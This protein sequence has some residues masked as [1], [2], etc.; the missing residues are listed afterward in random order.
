[1]NILFIT[2]HLPYPPLAGAR[3]RN[4]HLLKR[5]GMEH[6]IWLV[7]LSNDEDVDLCHISALL[8]FCREVRVFFEPDKGALD[9]PVEGLWYL[10]AGMPPDL[11]FFRSAAMSAYIR[12]LTK[13]VNFDVVEIVF[14]YMARFIEDLPEELHS[15]TVL[16]FIDV[17][18]SKYAR[19]SRVEERFAR[20]MREQLD[21]RM[22]RFWEPR[23]AERF[24]C[25]AM[26]SGTELALMYSMNPRLRMDVVPNGVDTKLNQPLGAKNGNSNLV[27]VGNMDYAANVDAMQYFMGDI[28]PLIRK[29]VPDVEMWIVGVNPRATIKAM[30]G[31]G[32]HVTGRVDDVRPYYQQSCVCVIPLRAGAGTRL[33]ILESMALGRV[34]VSTSI[35]YEGIE[36]NDGE[37]LL[38]ADTADDFA[39]KTI[40]LIKNE[41][42]RNKLA[43]NARQL[44]EVK[45]DW[46][47]VAE[48]LVSIYKGLNDE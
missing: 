33:K 34:V 44:V 9:R 17:L 22:M 20:R 11:R 36:A 1:M 12:Q 42:Q 2:H 4:F 18:F 43:I 41:D 15:K 13:E 25:C 45:Y 32:I 8:K 39:Q 24:G 27:F 29:E 14:S 31:N 7:V 3:L 5:L 47:I 35:G 21:G 16:T 38:V 19:I 30:D 23:I 37:H 40:Y 46:D 26:M 10:L 48:K 28:L 6:D